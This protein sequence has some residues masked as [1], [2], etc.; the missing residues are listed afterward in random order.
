MPEDTYDYIVVGAGTAGCLLAN[1]LSAD[2]SARVLLL[3][4]GGKDNYHWIHIPV[5]YLYLMG[6]PRTDWGFKTAAEPG[7][8]GR[9]LNYPRGARARRLLLHQRHDLH[10][11]PGARL[12][13]VAADGQSRLG[14]GRRAALLQEAPG[15]VGAGARRLRRAFALQPRRRV[16]HRAR[17]ASA[18]RSST[19]SARPRPRP[20][21]PRSTTSTAATTRAAATSTSTRRPACA[22]TPRRASCGRCCTGAT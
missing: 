4:A 17:R 3:E 22:G 1:R 12:R 14:L 11:R 16:A 21:S 8:N 20:A 5:G 15:P 7:L 19:P 13:P 9:S 18:G 2:P 10:A 6:N